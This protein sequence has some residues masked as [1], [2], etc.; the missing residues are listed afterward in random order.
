MNPL[1]SSTVLLFLLLTLTTTCNANTYT[2]QGDGASSQSLLW[3]IFG[4][5]YKGVNPSADLKYNPTSSG[6]GVADI[7]A[8]KVDFA[9]SDV[10]Q[11]DAYL[12]KNALLQFPI[13]SMLQII[14]LS[15]LLF[16]YANQLF[17]S[18]LSHTFLA[19][20]P[21]HQPHIYSFFFLTQ[22]WPLR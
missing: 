21:A 20:M 18:P 16:L 2:L 22:V 19:C 7:T 14:I 9:G 8:R 5:V 10:M 11:T 6:S 4:F 12:Q 15:L 1:S 3:N 13:A 17:F